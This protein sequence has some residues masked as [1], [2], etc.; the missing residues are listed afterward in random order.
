MHM[1]GQTPSYTGIHP[2]DPVKVFE[3]V[4]LTDVVVQNIIFLFAAYI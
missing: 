1:H 3:A 2:F 4:N